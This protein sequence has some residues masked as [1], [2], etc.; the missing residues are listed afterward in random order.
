VQR[1]HLGLDDCRLGLDA[2]ALHLEG[3]KRF[4]GSL[5]LDDEGSAIPRMATG[6]PL[7]AART[8]ILYA[9][10]LI[11]YDGEDLRNLP[12]LDPKGGA[13]AAAARDRSAHPA[14]RTHSRERPYRFCARLPG[15]APRYRFEEGRCRLPVWPVPRPDQGPQSRQHRGAARA[16]Q[17]LE[18]V[19]ALRN[20]FS[21]ASVVNV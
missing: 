17:E 20:T 14:Q 6:S 9:F 1:H 7:Q 3:G 2:A 11:E 18:Q 21:L 5:A 8:A 19:R 13:G 10:D 16:E 12:F 15:L 4:C